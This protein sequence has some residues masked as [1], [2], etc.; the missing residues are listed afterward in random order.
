MIKHTY[1]D[2][3]FNINATQKYNMVRNEIYNLQTRLLQFK[4][5][6]LIHFINQQ[7]VVERVA[8]S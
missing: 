2:Y 1:I 5:I 6:Q 4:D 8:N 7:K 3:T